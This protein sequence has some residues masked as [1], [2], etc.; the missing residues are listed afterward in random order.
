MIIVE[1]PDSGKGPIPGHHESKCR[2][3]FKIAPVIEAA[4]SYGA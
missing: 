3:A 1:D 4:V 2:Q